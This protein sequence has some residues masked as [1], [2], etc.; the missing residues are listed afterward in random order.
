[1]NGFSIS[2]VAEQAGIPATTLRYYEDQGIVG[3]PMRAGNGY[4]RY[5]DRDVQRLRFLG[6]ARR[7]DLTPSDLRDLAEA[8]DSDECA[9]V[10]H[11]LS[12]IVRSRLD[13]AQRQVV[14]L[15]EL[16]AEL[17]RVA[18]RVR[19]TPKPGP[20]DE[21]CECGLVHET[22]AVPTI[23]SFI[24]LTTAGSAPI[25]CTLAPEEMGTRLDDWQA[26]LALATER[27][28]LESGRAL[29]FPQEATVVAEL[30]RL[31]AA[32]QGCCSFFDFRM[33]LT[34]STVEFE[35]R[36][37]PEAQELITGLFGD[38]DEGNGR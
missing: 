26:L 11:R 35:V 17:Q 1:M 13:E 7:L 24:P 31:A 15:T 2:E 16:T 19:R 27:R 4:R 37:A 9:V 30:A 38:I 25:A 23:Q 33:H 10:Q 18:A 21:Q 3:A 34:G 6:R 20:C 5:S 14:E 8:W 32:E 12:G 22:V 36:A 28:R 29:I